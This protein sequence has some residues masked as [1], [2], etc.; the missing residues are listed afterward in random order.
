MC[1]C[2][3][4]DQLDLDGIPR[5]RWLISRITGVSIN[6][7]SFASSTSVNSRSKTDSFLADPLGTTTGTGSFAPAP[8]ASHSQ[9]VNPKMSSQSLPTL[10][11]SDDALYAAVEQYGWARDTDFQVD[12]NFDEPKQC[13]P[14]PAEHAHA[15]D[16][17]DERPVSWPY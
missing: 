17:S 14:H 4:K 16:S 6:S 13:S 5:D 12:I 11:P 15:A 1:G 8:A 2:T 9:G 10:K 7:D 3:C